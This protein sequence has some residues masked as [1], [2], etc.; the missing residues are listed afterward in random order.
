MSKVFSACWPPFVIMFT[1]T[2]ETKLNKIKICS[3][4]FDYTLRGN[5]HYLKIVSLKF[6]CRVSRRRRVWLHQKNWKRVIS[7]K[8]MGFFSRSFV[9]FITIW[10]NII[11]LK[12]N[13]QIVLALQLKINKTN[14]CGTFVKHKVTF[15]G[16]I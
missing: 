7:Q 8:S 12:Q 15:A 4:L 1:L 3:I 9:S 6:Q 10:L 11:L 5:W 2:Y 13:G 16:F 14:S